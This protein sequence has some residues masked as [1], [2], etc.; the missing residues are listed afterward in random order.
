MLIYIPLQFGN[1]KLRNELRNVF[2]PD[3]IRCAIVLSIIRS[4]VSVQWCHTVGFTK[5]CKIFTREDK[6][7]NW[8]KIISCRNYTSFFFMSDV[9]TAHARLQWLLLYTRD[10][11]WVISIGVGESALRFEMKKVTSLSSSGRR[12]MEYCCDHRST[13]WHH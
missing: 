5:I 3:R 10:P 4:P 11:V 2:Q 8:L 12:E 1:S 13:H 7:S 9:S 6:S